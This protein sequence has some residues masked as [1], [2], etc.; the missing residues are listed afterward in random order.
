MLLLPFAARLMPTTTS[1]CDLMDA[2]TAVE[3]AVLL[4]REM[5]ASATTQAALESG[6]SSPF[7]CPLRPAIELGLSRLQNAC[8]WSFGAWVS[9]LHLGTGFSFY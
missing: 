7:S 5:E 4:V 1:S 2:A 8:L 9:S 6:T 3:C